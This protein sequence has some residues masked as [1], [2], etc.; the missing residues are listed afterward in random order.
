MGPLQRCPIT[1]LLT[2]LG[3][4]H[5]G[6]NNN[7][8]K[9]ILMSWNRLFS[10]REITIASL[11]ILTTVMFFYKNFNLFC[12]ELVIISENC[13]NEEKFENGDTDN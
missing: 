9:A 5:T 7:L 4:N 12:R 13:F 11:V 10:L 1:E 8:V 6:C 3:Y 2:T